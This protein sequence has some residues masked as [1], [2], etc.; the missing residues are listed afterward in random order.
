MTDI[1][2]VVKRRGAVAVIVRGPR[3][4]VIR[5]A[6]G[7]A[8]P[9]TYC[10]PGGG[11]E[12]DESEEQAV[13]RELREELAATVRPVRRLWRSVTPWGVELSW[14]LT[15]LAEQA[16]L[17]ANPAEVASIHWFTLAELDSLDGLLA[18]NREFLKIFRETGIVEE[19]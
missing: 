1:Q 19:S 17:I 13:V 7:I 9:G 14:W 12:R 6:A 4:L 16:E 5:R 10:F 2:P 15:E 18:G 3:L 8:A 11:I